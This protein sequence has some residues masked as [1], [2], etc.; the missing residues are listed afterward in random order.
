MSE[1]IL[2]NSSWSVSK[3]HYFIGK[4]IVEDASV[5]YFITKKIFCQIYGMQ[6][7]GT[8]LKEN[9]KKNY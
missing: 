9:A 1:N 4:N 8:Q 5:T 2:Q 7:R 3:S 6:L